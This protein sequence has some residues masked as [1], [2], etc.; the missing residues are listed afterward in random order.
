[1]AG[2]QNEN[3]TRGDGTVEVDGGHARDLVQPFIA[4]W[5]WAIKRLQELR[6]RCMIRVNFINTIYLFRVVLDS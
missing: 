4:Q 6:K 3:G 5:G 2:R 1:M